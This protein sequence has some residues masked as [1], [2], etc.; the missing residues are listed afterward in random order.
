MPRN[1][2]LEAAA[3]ANPDDHDAWRVYADWLQAQGD[4]RGEL[5]SLALI[6]PT[7]F[8]SERK[9]LNKRLKA[10]EQELT[11]SWKAWMKARGIKW[12]DVQLRR[13][14]LEQVAA[15][16]GALRP[17]LDELFE[18]APL[19]QLVLRDAETPTLLDVLGSNPRWLAQLEYLKIEAQGGLDPTCIRALAE[20]PLPEL[21]GLNLTSQ[22]IGSEGCAALTELQTIQLRRLVLTANEIDDEAL[23][24]LLESPTRSQWRK[25]YLSGNPIEDPAAVLAAATGLEALEEL[26]L[27][28]IEGGITGMQVLG[29][30]DVLPGLRVL[31]ATPGWYADAATRKALSERFGAG[32]RTR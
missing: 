20:N 9:I 6:E 17:H 24:Q 23:G 2:S 31:E 13:G 29:N 12:A 32:F 26:Y 25:L 19:R 3:F 22:S 30:K 5:I 14:L 8:L 16:L 18:M 10:S 21:D 7:A 4:P 11:E 28:A 15:P 27:S 1:P